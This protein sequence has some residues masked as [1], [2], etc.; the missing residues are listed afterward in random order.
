[1]T[2]PIAAA[3]AARGTRKSSPGRRPARRPATLPPEGSAARRQRDAVEAIKAKRPPEPE[4][5]PEPQD[6]DKPAET[7]ASGR[8]WSAPA[9]PAVPKTVSTG[10]GFA[11]GVVAWAFGLAYLNNG[12]GGVQNLARAKFLNKI[13]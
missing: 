11:L 10:S 4:P 5:E 6:D 8:S 13:S 2:L 7:P 12:W 9:V 1:V 3:R